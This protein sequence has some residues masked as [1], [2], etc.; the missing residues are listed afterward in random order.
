MLIPTTAAEKKG[1]ATVEKGRIRDSRGEGRR[2]DCGREQR[3][4]KSWK[5]GNDAGR[6]SSISFQRGMAFRLLFERNYSRRVGAGAEKGGCCCGLCDV[7]C[8]GFVRQRSLSKKSTLEKVAIC[9]EKRGK[10]LFDGCDQ[11]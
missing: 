3:M 11:V 2:V 6:S 7:L 9:E 10:I 4:V 1:R 8:A 5:K